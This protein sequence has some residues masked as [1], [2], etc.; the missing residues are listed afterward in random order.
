M[1]KTLFCRIAKE[2]DILTYATNNTTDVTN[3]RNAIEDR[4]KMI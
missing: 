2:Q 3:Y 4:D 1:V